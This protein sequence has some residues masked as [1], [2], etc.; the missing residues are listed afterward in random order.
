MDGATELPLSLVSSKNE[1]I[2]QE[3]DKKTNY[4]DGVHVFTQHM[5]TTLLTS[6]KDHVTQNNDKQEPIIRKIG[7]Y[8]A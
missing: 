7:S 8:G 5:C 2:H 4:R 3:Q 6:H 1:L